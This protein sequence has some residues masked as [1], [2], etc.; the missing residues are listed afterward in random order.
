MFIEF[1][2]SVKGCLRCCG[3]YGDDKERFCFWI[4]YNLIRVGGVYID[5]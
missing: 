4:V 1:L 2:L 3:G 5:N